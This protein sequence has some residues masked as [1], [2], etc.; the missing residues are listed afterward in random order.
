MQGKKDDVFIGAALG[1]SFGGADGST[2]IALPNSQKLACF[3]GA[4]ATGVGL[5]IQTLIE[6]KRR[7]AANEVDEREKL[8]LAYSSKQQSDLLNQNEIQSSDFNSIKALVSGEVDAYMGFKFIRSERLPR[9]ATN[10]TYSVTD[11][12]VGAGGGTIT[13]AIS[14]RCVAWAQNGMLSSTGMDITA[15]LAE[16]ADKRFGTQVYVMESVGA[17]RLEEEKILEID[18]SEN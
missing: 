18:C 1:N 8:F 17:T 16:R 5:N 3:D 12:S 13:A 6:A 9:S 15:R 11:G 14:R 4:T 2:V 7:F 10:I